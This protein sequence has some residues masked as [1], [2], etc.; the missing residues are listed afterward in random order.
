MKREFL[1]N[2]LFLLTANL[3]IKPFYLF[4]I[5]RTVQ[6]TV[7]EGDYGLYFTLFNFTFLF[8][9]INDFGIQYYNNR[10]I[11]QH[12]HLLGKYFPNI[13]V[14]K[15]LLSVAYLALLLIFGLWA[16]YTQA[17][18]GMVLLIGANQVLTGLLLFLR[19]NISGLGRYRLDSLLSI[20]DRLLLII[21][22]GALLWGGLLPGPFRIEWFIWAQTAALGSTVLLA[23]AILRRHLP[24][25][26]LRLHWPFL[27]MLLRDSAP[28]ALS[29]FLMSAYYRLDGVM[30]ERLLPNGAVEAGIYASAYRL[31]EASNMIGYLFASLLLPIFSRMLKA[32]E[33]VGGLAQLGFQLIFTG[34]L[35]LFA[36][37]LFYPT[38]IMEALYESGSAYSGRILRYLIGSFVAVAGTYIFGTLLVANNSMKALNGVFAVSLVL[39]LGLNFALIPSLKG[40]GAALA[41]LATQFFVLSAEVYLAAKLLGLRLGRASFALPLAWFAL[42]LITGRQ[43]VGWADV[44]W[45]YRFAGLAS[46][47]GLGGL[48][49]A[50]GS[51]PGWKRWLRPNKA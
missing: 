13:L 3:L 16:G 11:A 22:C 45:G 9:I 5:D 35:S 46:L 2:I 41:T 50:V 39:N 48:A 7:P 49:L 23:L 44:F 51:N 8:Q 17:Y 1:L 4:G 24:V 47:G 26:R 20:T 37:V 32:G 42:L 12:R 29:I 6:N 15:G 30:L 14:L 34:A 28:F 18:F 19:S 33:P 10:N 38:E 21:I 31:Y 36:G 40:E 27:W 25:V 43:S